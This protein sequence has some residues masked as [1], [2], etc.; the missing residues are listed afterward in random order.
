[1]T[2]SSPPAG[3]ILAHL[4]DNVQRQCHSHLLRFTGFPGCNNS[5]VHNMVLY[6][7]LLLIF[8]FSKS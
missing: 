2:L 1:M 8:S 3:P 5:V 4:E 6:Y 7:R